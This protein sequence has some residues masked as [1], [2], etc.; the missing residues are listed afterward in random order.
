MISFAPFNAQTSL[1]FKNVIFWSLLMLLMLNVA[2]LWAIVSIGIAFEFLVKGLNY[3][4]PHT[5][6]ILDQQQR[7]PN[8]FKF[9]T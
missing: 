8:F 9:I 6:A 3:Y 5:H 1:L 2:S 7:V 4:Q